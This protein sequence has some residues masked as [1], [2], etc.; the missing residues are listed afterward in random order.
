MLDDYFS[1]IPENDTL[2]NDEFV[3]KNGFSGLAWVG[4]QR[5]PQIKDNLMRDIHIKIMNAHNL[6]SVARYM[7]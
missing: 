4:H 6:E 3:E 2:R 5:S 1:D 7:L